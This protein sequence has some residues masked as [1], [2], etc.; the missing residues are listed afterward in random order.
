MEKNIIL[1]HFKDYWSEDG[2]VHKE[3]LLLLGEYMKHTLFILS[4]NLKWSF[5]SVIDYNVIV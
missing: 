5:S 4:E 2:Q 1:K 3:Q